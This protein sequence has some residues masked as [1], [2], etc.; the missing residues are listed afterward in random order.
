MMS[1]DVYIRCVANSD[2]IQDMCYS[3]YRQ[4]LLY[5]VALFAISWYERT[6]HKHAYTHTRIRSHVTG[7]HVHTVKPGGDMYVLRGDMYVTWG[8]VC[9]VGTFMLHCQTSC[10]TKLKL[11]NSFKGY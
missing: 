10:F 1:R 8:H 3:D 2:V 11:T 6:Y 4:Q 5:R 7:F 9:Y